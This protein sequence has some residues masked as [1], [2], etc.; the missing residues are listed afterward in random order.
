LIATAIAWYGTR[1]VPPPLAA[2]PAAAS[3]ATVNGNVHSI[4]L[5]HAEAEPPPGPH[6]RE[7]VIACTTCHSAALVLNQPPFPRAKWGEIVQKMVK[8]FGA[9]IAPDEEPA[10]IEYL[11]TIRGK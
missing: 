8:T 11:V 5:P 9:P 6:H 2:A 7:F 3:P 10:L 1:D 4:V